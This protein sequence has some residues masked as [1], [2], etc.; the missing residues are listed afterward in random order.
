LV[1][2]VKRIDLRGDD[3]ERS[4]G[5]GPI[6]EVTRRGAEEMAEVQTA[7]GPTDVDALGRVLMHEHVFYFMSD[8][9]GDYPWR[10]EEQAVAV[11]VEELRRLKETGFSTI[12]DLTVFGLGRNVSRVA[13][14]AEAAEFNV[15]VATGAYTLC[16]LPIYFK[17]RLATVGPSYLEDL[18]VREIEEGIG[19][20]GIRAGILKCVTD[21]A[22]LTPDVEVV[23]RSVARAH[24]RTGA[25]IST[26]TDVFY[27]SGLIQQK[28]FRQEGVDLSRVIIGHS[29]DT[30]DLGYLE[31][32][33]D[34][35]SYLGMD[36]F[37]LYGL[38]SFDDRVDTVAK[39]CA[40]GYASRIVLS[41]DSNCGNDLQSLGEMPDV[42][43][44][45]IPEAV[46]PALLERGVSEEEIDL[47]VRRNPRAIFEQAT[48]R[49]ATP[50]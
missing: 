10:E 28:V 46:L 30:T 26:H 12:V 41:H 43:Y 31:R 22:G 27:E 32:L 48:S 19:D 45:Q 37:G 3:R 36:R 9:H 11:A 13:R 50:A 20:S 21:R 18:F 6:G 17:N 15:I 5:P 25:P 39:L 44:T 33:A 29:G 1:M 38:C 42:G 16:D 2:V 23:L 7:T 14:V 49:P 40:R 35:G 47:M 4:K 8:I 34:A 24:L